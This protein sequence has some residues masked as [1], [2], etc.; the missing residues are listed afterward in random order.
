[1][2]KSFAAICLLVDDFN[3]SLNFY[4]NI[5]GFEL[6]KREGNYADFKLGETMFEISQKEDAVS[7]IPLKYMLQG[8][9]EVISFKV[10]E[11]D[12]FIKSIQDKNVE[13]IEGP[14]VTEWGEKVAYML[15][16]DKN[17]IEISEA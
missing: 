6:H 16:P 2:N 1:M 12:S 15:D 11:F 7:M 8:G 13:I 3:K 17:I 5:L 14:K 9:G 10:S 4:T